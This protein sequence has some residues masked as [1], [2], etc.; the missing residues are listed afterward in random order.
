MRETLGSY[1]RGPQWRNLRIRLLKEQARK[2]VN[3][4][5]RSDQ[6]ATHG[7]NTGTKGIPQDENNFITG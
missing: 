6:K 7:N 4:C 3:T 5:G 1:L 2:C